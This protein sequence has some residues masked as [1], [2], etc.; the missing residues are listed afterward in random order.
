MNPRQAAPD[1]V[2][3]EEG[4]AVPQCGRTMLEICWVV[5]YVNAGKKMKRKVKLTDV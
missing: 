3:E 1:D 4:S 5:E 2:R